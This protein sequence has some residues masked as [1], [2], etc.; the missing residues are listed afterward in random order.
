M[1][2]KA[3]Q[4]PPP[5]ITFRHRWMLVKLDEAERATN[6]SLTR[7]EI[8]RGWSEWV[9]DEIRT[10]LRACHSLRSSPHPEGKQVVHWV[11]DWD[12]IPGRIFDP[13]ETDDLKEVVQVASISI[14]DVFEFERLYSNVSTLA[15]DARLA[16][17]AAG[18]EVA[19]AIGIAGR[20]DSL[21]AQLEVDKP[22]SEEFVEQWRDSLTPLGAKWKDRR[23][24]EWK[25]GSGEPRFWVEQSTVPLHSL[26]PIVHLLDS[27]ARHDSKYT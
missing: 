2:S 24:K 6:R 4:K 12:G 18:D 5:P 19:G 25:S 7:E 23:G 17:H 22:I 3:R 14:S 27:V 1:A 9:L 26:G 10:W 13:R 21:A 16:K 15:L 20:L 11:K 8:D